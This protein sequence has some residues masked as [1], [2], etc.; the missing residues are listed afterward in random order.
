MN[1]HGVSYK[2]LRKQLVGNDKKMEA[3]IRLEA[4]KLDL[5]ICLVEYRE[6]R[7][8]TQKQLA[9]KLGVKQQVVAKIEQGSNITFETLFR[10][11]E[12]LGIVLK[13]EAIQRKR[14]ESVLQFIS[15]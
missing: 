13:V 3:E 8:L 2:E 10:F 14:K 7:G 9:Q 5:V 1:P 4:A 6:K 15:H 11:L 12:A